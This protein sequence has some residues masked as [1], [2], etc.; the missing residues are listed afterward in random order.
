MIRD[1]KMRRYNE[2]NLDTTFGVMK[3]TA[4][5]LGDNLK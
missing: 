4:T 5:S 2:L 3:R 1:Y